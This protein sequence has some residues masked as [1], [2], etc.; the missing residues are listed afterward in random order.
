MS[1]LRQD[2]NGLK[3]IATGA[4]VFLSISLMLIKLFASVYTGSLA[5]LSSLVDSISDIFASLIT[6]IA[7]RFSTLPASKKHRYGYGKAEA[8]SALVQSAFVAGSGIFVIYEGIDRIFN[9]RP[10][11]D[12]FFGILVMVISFIATLLL[13]IF[14]KY[15]VKKTSSIAVQ[16]DSLH[17]M[18]D[19]ITNA[20]II[21]SLLVVKFLNIWWFDTLTA[22]FVSGYLLYNAYKIAKSAV[23]LLLDK[24]LETDV[25]KSI[26]N[27]VKNCSFCLGMHDLRTR[28]LG[29]IYIFEFHL[30]LDGNLSLYNAHKLTDIIEQEVKNLYPGS[31]V[32]IHQDPAGVEEERLDNILVK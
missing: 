1:L 2:N 13:I 29:G 28:D 16:A 31:Q 27:I 25:R 21:L 20:T 10:L 22:I 17:Y 23:S 6:F 24:E 5:V 15:V 32:I 3:K 30:E 7:V 11:N 14:Q 4:S 26:E 12:T 9:P 8:L 19:I 18:V